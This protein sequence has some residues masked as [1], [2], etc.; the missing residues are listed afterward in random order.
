MGRVQRKRLCRVAGNGGP[1]MGAPKIPRGYT[2]LMSNETLRRITIADVAK[3][4]G[5]NAS[6]VSRVLNARASVR[7]DTRERIESAARAL[8]YLPSRTARS[9]ATSRTW[10]IGVLLPDIQNL[11]HVEFL[12]GAEHVVQQFGYSLVVTDGQL[13]ADIQ[14][15]ALERFLE[16]RVDGLIVSRAFTLSHLT[17]PFQKAG[18][19]VEPIEVALGATPVPVAERWRGS[20]TAYRRLLGLG[21]R[22][23]AI[24]VHERADAPERSPEMRGRID[25]L[26]AVSDE[27]P[28]GEVTVHLAPASVD[29]D[30]STQLERVMGGPNP[31]TALVAGNDWMTAPLLGA[32]RD[33]GLDIPGDVSFLTYG[34]SRWAA[35]YR[36]P[37]SAIRYH[38]YEEGQV[39]ASRVLRRLGE[40]ADENLARQSLAVD[41]F[42]ERG[43]MAAPRER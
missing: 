38:Y 2:V 1:G 27:Y 22:S 37:I 19:P 30:V 13:R 41:E 4:A 15:A 17:Q 9:L 21:H 12:R 8:G 10:T 5:V 23:V 7:A 6:T 42:I 16:M 33:A 29:A 26:L 24:F 11:M 36:P 20:M 43:S 3:R 18:V 39:L 31:P 25:A 40:P 14:A 34:D 35:A 32:V 28:G